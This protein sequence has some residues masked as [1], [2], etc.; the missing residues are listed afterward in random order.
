MNNNSLLFF[1]ASPNVFT[2][3][4]KN[5]PATEVTGIFNTSQYVFTFHN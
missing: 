5:R 2:I 3:V 4:I 1:N